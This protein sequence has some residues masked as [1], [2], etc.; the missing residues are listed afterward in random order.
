MKIIITE[1]QKNLLFENS[2]KDDLIQ[3]IK[4]DGFKSVSELVGGSKNLMKL[5][6]IDTPMDFLNLFNDLDVVQSKEIPEYTLFRY[7]PN[8]NLMVYNRSDEVAYANHYDVYVNYDD[9]WSVLQD[10][11]GLN[12]Y[13]IRELIKVWLDEVYNL[14]GVTPKRQINAVFNVG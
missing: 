7:N 5:L 6:K 13:D 12:Y 14:R 4:D 10:D 9:I 8:H 3:A 11:F 2:V 1:S